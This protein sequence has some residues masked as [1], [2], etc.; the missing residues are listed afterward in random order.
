MPISLFIVET[1]EIVRVGLRIWFQDNNA[2]QIVGEASTISE[3]REALREG[4]APDVILLD[5][6]LC[7]T[8]NYEPLRRFQSDFPDSKVLLWLHERPGSRLSRELRSVGAR[9]Y[10][11]KS[12][13]FPDLAWAITAVAEGQS[14]VAGPPGSPESDARVRKDSSGDKTEKNILSNREREIIYL[15]SEGFS[16]S[17]I[18]AQ[19]GISLDTVKTH[20]RKILEKLNAQDRTQ[21]AIQAVRAGII[22]G[23]A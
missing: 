16:N 5:N 4:A 8:C 10:C 20:V 13:R 19:L 18:S 2:V 3:L 6:A 7:T 11:T 12:S 9:G 15:V 23:K 21:A 14:W 1:C 17:Q 22:H